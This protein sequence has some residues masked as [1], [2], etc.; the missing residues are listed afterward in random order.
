[1]HARESATR[2]TR[3]N[4]NLSPL[5]LQNTSRGA[6]S[7]SQY[8]IGVLSQQC[9]PGGCPI[10]AAPQLGSASAWSNPATW[11]GG[12]VPAAGADV[13]INNTMNVILDVSP[14]TI[15][16]LTVLGRLSFQ[17]FGVGAPP[18]VLSVGQIVEPAV[19]VMHDTVMWPP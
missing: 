12:V 11:P 15:G 3:Q 14:P 13:L 4:G 8:K 17:D 2:S 16:T 6:G 10:P 9:P 1:M 5:L 7:S 19:R 18:L